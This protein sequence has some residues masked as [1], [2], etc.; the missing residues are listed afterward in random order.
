[1]MVKQIES[2]TSEQIAQIPAWTKK[3]IDIGLS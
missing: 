3:W 2:L 1:M